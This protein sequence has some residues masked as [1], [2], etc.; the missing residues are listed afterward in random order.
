MARRD[1]L[2]VTRDMPEQPTT[3]AAPPTGTMTTG[4]T[5]IGWLQI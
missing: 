3:A 2:G 4:T 5:T 1:T